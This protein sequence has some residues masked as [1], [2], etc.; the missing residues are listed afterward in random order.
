MLNTLLR[1]SM[2][3]AKT[4]Y[5][6]STLYYQISKGTFPK[7]VKLGERAVG[8][9]AAEVDAVIQ[10]RVS[11]KPDDEIR[12]LIKQLVSARQSLVQV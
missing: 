6:R 11:G 7:P 5:P 9:I 1:F 3:K 12:G 10:A 2:V 8:W 4:G